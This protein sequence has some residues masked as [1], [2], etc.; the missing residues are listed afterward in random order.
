M[1]ILLPFLSISFRASSKRRLS[2]TYSGQIFV[3]FSTLS[4]TIFHLLSKHFST[5][6]FS[7]DCNDTHYYLGLVIPVYRL[8]G[9]FSLNTTIIMRI[10]YGRRF[11]ITNYVA[12]MSSNVELGGPSQRMAR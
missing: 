7:T 8:V 6:Y 3:H 2:L 1:A 10:F 9:D 4:P 5:Q 12:A 11:C